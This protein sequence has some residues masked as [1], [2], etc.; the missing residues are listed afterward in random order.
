MLLSRV[1][2]VLAVVAAVVGVLVVM[3]RDGDSGRDQS[4]GL[5]STEPGG[6]RAPPPGKAPKR[7]L[8]RVLLAFDI[9]KSMDCPLEW[10]E[11][12][13]PFPFPHQTPPDVTRRVEGAAAAVVPIEDFSR[14]DQLGLWI[15]ADGQPTK[16]KP[17][18]FAHPEYV[19]EIEAAVGKQ[20]ERAREELPYGTPLYATIARGVREVRSRWLGKGAVNA[21]VIITDGSNATRTFN[22]ADDVNKNLKPDHRAKP[23]EVLITS[24]YDPKCN[25]LDAIVGATCFPAKTRA[26]VRCAL[27]KIRARLTK[28]SPPGCRL[29]AE[30]P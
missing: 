17:I 15:F 28:T 30:S 26:E 25:E 24:A 4:R 12:C 20:A 7:P 11:K 23:V 2:R 18:K 16:V 8:K 21:L 13:P 5:P 3:L 14:R 10:K 27:G 19:G 6:P 29:K 22:R 9:S 1:V